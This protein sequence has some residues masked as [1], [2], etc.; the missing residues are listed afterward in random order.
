M[1]SR[2][3]RGCGGWRVLQA[4]RMISSRPP[5]VSVSSAVNSMLLRSLRDHYLE[6]SKM[7]PPPKVSPPS[8]FSIIKGALDS[9]GPVLKRSYGNEEIS[10]YVMRLANIIPGGDD[11]DD[12]INQLFLHVQVSKPG[13]K[14]S[15]H[16]L[17][18]LYPDA[19]GIHS[20]SMRPKLQSSGFLVLPS[21]YN[22]PVFQD[23]NERMRD[24]LHS[25][26]EER[27]VNESLFPFLQAWLYVKDHRNLMHWFQRVG[28][29]INEQ[30]PSKDASS[31]M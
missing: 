30:K 3:R 16:F 24:A 7:T 25:Y 31:S 27:G 14:D 18:G 10:I 19:L 28:T 12:N 13:Q 22:G 26:I 9:E 20:V 1:W 11:E 17:C 4:R 15:L 29:F 23:L 8:P 5:P 6:V 2:A 21:Q